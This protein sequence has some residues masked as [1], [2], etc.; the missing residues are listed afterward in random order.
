MSNFRYLAENYTL[1]KRDGT[2]QRDGVVWDGA[3]A[4][5][6][7][8]C[9][10]GGTGWTQDDGVATDGGWAVK[11][12][13]NATKLDRRSVYTIIRPHAKFQHIPKTFL[14]HS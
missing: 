14:C 1:R 12:A 9:W 11:R 2:V 4:V 5:W 7:E 10:R 6:F 3:G 8:G 13:P